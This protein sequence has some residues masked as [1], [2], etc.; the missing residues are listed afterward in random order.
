M[1]QDLQ[2]TRLQVMARQEASAVNF[3]FS[4][5]KKSNA[6]ASL[7]DYSVGVSTPTGLVSDISCA[8]KSLVRKSAIK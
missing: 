4:S 7:E 6:Q 5:K 1:V 2:E 8:K 3:P